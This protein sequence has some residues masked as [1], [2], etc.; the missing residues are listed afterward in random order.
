MQ[1]ASNEA[2][3]RRR[4][5]ASHSPKTTPTLTLASRNMCHRKSWQDLCVVF[6]CS[7]A[8]QPADLTR[9]TLAMGPG[10]SRLGLVD[11]EASRLAKRQETGPGAG[12]GQFGGNHDSD[13]HLHGARKRW[14]GWRQAPGRQRRAEDCLREKDG[15]RG[16]RW[17]CE[18]RGAAERRSGHQERGG[19]RPGAVRLPAAGAV[20]GDRDTSQSRVSPARP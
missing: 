3:S 5:C 10:R 14:A 4:T 16:G 1:P 6:C 15:R 2:S 8:G 19:P 9:E 20:P 7:S 13:V 11:L 18:Q 12:G 17:R